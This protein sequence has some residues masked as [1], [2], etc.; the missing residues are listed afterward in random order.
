M[1]G[2]PFRRFILLM[3]CIGYFSSCDNKTQSNEINTTETNVPAAS[4]VPIPEFNADSA[5][6]YAVAQ[7]K[8]GPRVPGSPAHKQ[9]G[10]W[11]VSQ[12]KS[13]GWE[14]I[15]Q[16]ATVPNNQGG[17]I[18]IRNIIA[19]IK[20]D[21]GKR[22]MLSAHWDSRPIADA[23]PDPKNAN[24]A[25]D[26][27]ND[28]ASGVAVLLELA[29]VLS[30]NPPTVGVDICFWD[31]EDGGTSSVQESWCLGSQYWA[32]NPH[33]PGYKAIY[34]INL[35]MV[36]AKD[37]TF[38][39]EAYSVRGGGQLTMRIWQT[40]H[41]LGYGAN[42]PYQQKGQIIDDHYFINKI[43]GIPYVDII[44]LSL[45]PDESN[46]GF[47]PHWHTVEDKIDKLS[48]ATLKAVG[49]TVLAVVVRET[50][51]TP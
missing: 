49:R 27:A 33:K 21:A 47:F 13:F 39:Q 26:G 16:Q 22:I 7:C 3:F 1:Q 32:Q 30:K 5:Y 20:P 31:A 18:G 2:I 45:T 44:H 41:E 15:E 24:K 43:A 38:P 12:L 51:P 35:D 19:S 8:F 10:N 37:A 29:R 11:L 28:G 36:G 25:I 14:V 6:A 23:D 4:T 17:Q 9:C 34:G 48:P 42:F 50:V 40:A 46:S